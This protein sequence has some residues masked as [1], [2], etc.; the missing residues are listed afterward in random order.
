[1][2]ALSGLQLTPQMLASSAGMFVIVAG[3]RS[4]RLQE[5][6]SALNIVRDFAGVATYVYPG[7]YNDARLG[8]L[9]RLTI[10]RS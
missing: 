2:Q 3:P 1:M 7:A 8:N 9:L 5:V 6:A 10:I 4:M